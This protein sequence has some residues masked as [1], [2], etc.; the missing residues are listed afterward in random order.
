MKTAQVIYN[1]AR[2]GLGTTHVVLQT[3]ADAT[4]RAE[5]EVVKKTG[6][7]ENGKQFML[8]QEQLGQY[9]ATR[10]EATKRVQQ[11]GK[12]KIEDIRAMLNKTKETTVFK[13]I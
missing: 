7:W 4:V 1:I 5:L 3:L 13:T 10:L 9:K 11:K 2:V 8:D 12:A 6:Y